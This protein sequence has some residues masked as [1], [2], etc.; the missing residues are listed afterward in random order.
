MEELYKEE[1]A[2]KEYFTCE[3]PVRWDEMDVNGHVN[4]GNYMDYYSEA[5]IEAMG[6]EAFKDLR[7]KGIGPAI[8]R[9]EVDFRKELFHPDSVH[10]VT[11]IE[12]SI[13]K[14]RVVVG[15]RIYSV[16]RKELIAS[17]KFYSIFMD[18]HKRRPVAMPDIFRKKF[19][20][21]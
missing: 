7:E 14:T 16:S 5:R 4:Y 13:S 3:L 8:Y 19:G 17:A 18:V 6:Q 1:L 10:M 20:L 12:E 2:D 21:K 15:Q 11:W 9:A